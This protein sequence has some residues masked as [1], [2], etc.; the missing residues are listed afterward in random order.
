MIVLNASS[1]YHVVK[2]HIGFRVQTT[3]IQSAS[4]RRNNKSPIGDSN[5]TTAAATTS[6]PAANLALADGSQSGS[7]YQTAA[8]TQTMNSAAISTT[9]SGQAHNNMMPFLTIRY[10]IALVG[11][12]PSRN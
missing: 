11:V 4:I 8:P 6:T 10:C 3:Y 9:G 2:K 12:F 1:T 7:F 5:A